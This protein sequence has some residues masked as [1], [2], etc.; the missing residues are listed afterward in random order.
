VGLADGGDVAGAGG[1]LGGLRGACDA[2]ADGEHA[3]VPGRAFWGDGERGG[4][5]GAACA[6]TS[7]PSP[8]SCGE[9]VGVRGASTSER[10]A[11]RPLTP[12]LI[13]ARLSMRSDSR[14]VYGAA[15]E[16]RRDDGGFGGRDFGRFATGAGL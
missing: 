5:L 10:L 12:T 11:D 1:L 15:A 2:A 3:A 13:C 14:I 16:A 6:G 4:A 9:R 7:A 8:R